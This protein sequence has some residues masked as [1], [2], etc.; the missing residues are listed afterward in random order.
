[1]MDFN[2]DHAPPL[3]PDRN[4][5]DRFVHA[6]FAHASEGGYISLRSFYDDKQ[7]GVFQIRPVRLNGGGLEPVIAAAAELAK[8]ALWPSRAIV[9]CPPIASFRSNKAGEANLDRKSTRLNSSH[10]NISY[11]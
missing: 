9:V 6:L 10:A 3:E 7:S 8:D 2:A 5:I 11:A 1:M 4:E